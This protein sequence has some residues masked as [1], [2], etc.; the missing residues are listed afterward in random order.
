LNSAS[1]FEED[2]APSALQKQKDVGWALLNGD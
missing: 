2:G 1:C